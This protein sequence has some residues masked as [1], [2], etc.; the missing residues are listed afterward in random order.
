MPEYEFV[1]DAGE[2]GTVFFQ[3]ADD[4]PKIGETIEHDGQLIR[5]IPSKPRVATGFLHR[6]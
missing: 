4:A 1:N 3:K 2:Y 6:S 5:R